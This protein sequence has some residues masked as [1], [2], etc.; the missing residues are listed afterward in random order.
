MG[1]FSSYNSDKSSR[2]VLPIHYNKFEIAAEALTAIA[3]IA[4]ITVLIMYYGKLHDSIPSHFGLSGQA[5]E[6]SGKSSLFLMLGLNFF[7]VIALTLVSFKP[8]NFN[9]QVVITEQNAQIQYAMARRMI[10]IAKM[11]IS[12]LFFS[13]VFQT[14]NIAM[15]KTSTIGWTTWFFLIC[16]VGCSLFMI[17]YSKKHR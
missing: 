6:F 3:L 10:I 11:L 14:I 8:H 2:P 5:D 9:Y 15:G 17:L 4:S 13:L 7:L 12:W 16:L 1:V